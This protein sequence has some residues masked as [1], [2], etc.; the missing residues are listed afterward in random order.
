MLALIMAGGMG[1]R[2]LSKEEK[3]MLL[4]KGQPIISYVLT[5][6]KNSNCFE[7]IIA[8]VSY[9]TPKTAQFLAEAGAAVANSSGSDYVMDLNYALGLVRPN[10]AFII[11]GD[12]PL[13]D[14]D[15]IKKIV[16]S[17]DSCKKPCLTVMVSKAMLMHLGVS[18]DYCLEHDGKIVCNTGVSV[19]D[20]SKV[21][22]YSNIDEEFLVMDR[23]QLAI[24]V[25]TKHE[26]EIA[27]KFLI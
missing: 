25:N 23:M 19:I 15:T 6:L 13:I 26:L 9:N 24:N 10:K 20:S 2:M 22:Q 3:P 27:E 12:M 5:A 16:G 14:C 11:S 21:S 17:F 1:R 4:V 18:T 8:Y 7:K